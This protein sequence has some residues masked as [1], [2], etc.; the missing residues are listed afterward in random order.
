MHNVRRADREAYLQRLKYQLIQFASFNHN[1]Y[2]KINPGS[3]S[4]APSSNVDSLIITP[5][6]HATATYRGH[7]IEFENLPHLAKV[8][9]AFSPRDPRPAYYNCLRT[10][11][12]HHHYGETTPKST[13]KH[14]TEEIPELDKLRARALQ[15][16][17]NQQKTAVWV[18]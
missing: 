11:I 12:L 6:N 15:V 3:Y 7:E 14:S 2:V 13:R 17:T 5:D 8:L 16:I 4:Y 18:S 10:E 9:R 1:Q